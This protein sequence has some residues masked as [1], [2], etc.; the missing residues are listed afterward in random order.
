MEEAGSCSEGACEMQ[1]L[2]PMKHSSATG[3]YRHFFRQE[4][5][6]LR[7]SVSAVVGVVLS[8]IDG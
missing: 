7:E 3:G 1:I 5:A 8:E 4:A 2:V 6:Y